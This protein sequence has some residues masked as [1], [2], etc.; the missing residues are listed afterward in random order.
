MDPA[1]A[2][3]MCFKGLEPCKSQTEAFQ[4]IVGGV[5]F[6]QQLALVDPV[7]NMVFGDVRSTVE[8]QRTPEQFTKN[9]QAFTAALFDHGLEVSAEVVFSILAGQ[10]AVAAQLASELNKL[11]DPAAVASRVVLHRIGPALPIRNRLHPFLG[12]VAPVAT[13]AVSS[14]TRK[15]GTG[16]SGGAV[17]AAAKEPTRVLLQDPTRFQKKRAYVVEQLERLKERELK[18]QRLREK[19]ERE[20]A[21]MAAEAAKSHELADQLAAQEQY[22]KESLLLYRSDPTRV[23]EKKRRT[24]LL[25][26]LE[27]LESQAA[28]DQKRMARLK[29]EQHDVPPR[30]EQTNSPNR[31]QDEIPVPEPA[32]AAPVTE[33][34]TANQTRKKKLT[35]PVRLKEPS[36]I[37]FAYHNKK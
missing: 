6:L 20:A 19:K 2:V 9:W 11:N 14:P 16:I 31:R 13:G 18:A 32:S 29:K 36:A 10:W 30:H 5:V 35:S 23:A 37:P 12:Q 28:S 21:R 1:Q 15:Q 24:E 33:T 27:A 7:F 25:K 17:M 34:Q 8:T 26:E 3:A 22:L 4:L